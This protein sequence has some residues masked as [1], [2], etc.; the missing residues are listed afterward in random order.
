MAMVLSKHDSEVQALKA[1][2]ARSSQNLSA[3]SETIEKVDE[4]HRRIEGFRTESQESLFELYRAQ[5]VL[6]RTREKFDSY[7]RSSMS[8]AM[9]NQDEV[10]QRSCAMYWELFR[11]FHGK[12]SRLT[13]RIF[14]K[15]L[16]S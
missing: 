10:L 16:V 6:D 8:V 5:V 11:L 3:Y 12:L 13:R 2:L 7:P 1:E 9:R 4:F 14:L 15:Q